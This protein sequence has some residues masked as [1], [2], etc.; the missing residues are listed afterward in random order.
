M[1]RRA[2]LIRRIGRQNTHNKTHNRPNGKKGRGNRV[3]EFQKRMP[4]FV[5]SQGYQ[6]AFLFL[7]YSRKVIKKS[8]H[9]IFSV[10]HS[11]IVFR[12]VK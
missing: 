1:R 11:R 4:E 6:G 10:A 7:S 12:E 3:G 9:T 2:L 5:F 8:A